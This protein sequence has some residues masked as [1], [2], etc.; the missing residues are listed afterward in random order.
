MPKSAV[1]NKITTAK[2]FAPDKSSIQINFRK[3]NLILDREQ[4]DKELA[5]RAAKAGAGVFLRHRFVNLMGNKALI[6]DKNGN[7]SSYSFDYL[8]GADGPLSQVAK[9]AGIFG[10]RKFVVGMQVRAEIEVEKECVEFWLGFGSFGWVVPE[11]KKIARVG[12][13]GKNENLKQLIKARCKNAK[14]IENQAGLIPIYSPNI[15]LQKDNILLLGDA[16]AQTKASTFGGIIPGLSAAKIL[17]EDIERYETNFKKKWGKEL[18][19]A[20]MMRK[21]LDRFSQSDYNNLLSLASKEKIRA[22]IGKEDRDFPTKF[23]LK[24]FF[25]EPRLA[26]FAKKLIS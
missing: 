7:C 1:I 6:E 9:S 4:F 22:I 16:A 17:A 3:P 23:L 11:H 26:L 24:L 13:I 18:W 20:L 15:K 12:V 2:I 21:I 19:L 25:A 10:N 8:I 14:I 5:K